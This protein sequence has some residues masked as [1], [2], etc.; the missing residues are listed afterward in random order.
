MSRVIGSG[1]FDVLC[2][3]GV[4]DFGAFEDVSGLCKVV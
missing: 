4:D 1:N 2:S 3:L